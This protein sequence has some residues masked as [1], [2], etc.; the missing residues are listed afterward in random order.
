MT[1]AIPRRLHETEASLLMATVALALAGRELRSVLLVGEAA[2][3]S[4]A[5]LADAAQVA[6]PGVEAYAIDDSPR[7]TNLRYNHSGAR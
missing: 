4:A 2:D 1:G 5:V 6:C 7:F 3:R